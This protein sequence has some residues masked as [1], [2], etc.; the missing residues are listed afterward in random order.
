MKE[1]YVED[2]AN[3]NGHESCADDREVVREALDSGI[4]RLGIEPRKA[5][6]RVPTLFRQ[7]EGNIRNIVKRDVNELCVVGDPT[8]V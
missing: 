3:H 8:H 7:M 6:I 1:P 5:C 2:I 4:Y